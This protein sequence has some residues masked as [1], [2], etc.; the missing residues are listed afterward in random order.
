MISKLELIHLNV[1]PSIPGIIPIEFKI[2]IIKNPIINHGIRTLCVGLWWWAISSLFSSLTSILA[3]TKTTTTKNIILIILNTVASSTTGSPINLAEPITCPTDCNI[4]PI[5]AELCKTSLLYKI[6][7]I[8]GKSI[9]NI[10]PVTFTIVMAIT[11]SESLAFITGDT[12]PIADEPHTAFPADMS[13]EYFSPKPNFL[14]I[15]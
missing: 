11:L 4:P 14:P 9:I 13:N 15:K 8:N 6:D 2:H 10:V 7:V 3:K 1:L 5:N 12:D